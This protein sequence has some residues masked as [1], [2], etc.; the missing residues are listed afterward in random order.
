VLYQS[1]GFCLPVLMSII[2]FELLLGK[3]LLNFVDHFYID[4]G[5]INALGFTLFFSVDYLCGRVPQVF[6]GA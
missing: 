2:A 4:F 3:F 5:I 1:S 6:S